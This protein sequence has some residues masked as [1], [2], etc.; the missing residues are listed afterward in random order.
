MRLWTLRLRIIPLLLV[1]PLLSAM[2]LRAAAPAE[3]GLGVGE[4]EVFEDGPGHEIDLEIRFPPRNFHLLPRFLPKVSPLLGTI[5]TTKGTIYAYAGLRADLPLGH[6]WWFSPSFSGGVY[7]RA[8]GQDLGGPVEFRS[9]LELSYELRQG[10]RLG[11]CLYHLSNGGIF[12]PNPGSESL[13]FTYSMALGR[14][15]PSSPSE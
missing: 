3:V 14:R 8:N 4:V 10:S 15:S 5:A 2:P 1:L 13:V 9:A 6:R 7:Y 11:V 12:P